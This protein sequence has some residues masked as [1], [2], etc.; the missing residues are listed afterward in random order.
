MPALCRMLPCAAVSTDVPA[1]TQRTSSQP[2]SLGSNTL[3]EH[4]AR[5]TGF[6]N[7]PIN[8]ICDITEV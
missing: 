2:D 7:I 5:Y 6:Q 4:S 3:Y 1:D 8:F